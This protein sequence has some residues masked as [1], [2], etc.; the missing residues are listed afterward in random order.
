MRSSFVTLKNY[1]NTR[2]V[3]ALWGCAVGY[4]KEVFEKFDFDENLN[5]YALGED[6]EFSYR[7]SKKFDLIFT[8]KIKFSHLKSKLNRAKLFEFGKM[9]ICNQF[10][11]FKKNNFTKVTD[12]IFLYY[13]F[14]GI[15]FIHTFHFITN[16]SKENASLLSG[17]IVG[18]FKT[19]KYIIYDCGIR[20]TRRH[21]LSLNMI[22]KV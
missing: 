22:L 4:R 11:F 2:K 14:F 12:Y 20:F 17:V 16:P 9:L 10:Y 18:I 19:L 3:S 8:P 13:S 15:I 6:I 5:G 7:I 1:N 21:R